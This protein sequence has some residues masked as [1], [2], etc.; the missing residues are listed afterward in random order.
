MNLS[1]KQILETGKTEAV[2]WRCSV[3]RCARVS[4]SDLRP[5]TLSK[6]RLW[7]RYRPV[8]FAKLLWNTFFHRTPQVAASGKNER[9]KNTL[10]FYLHM[11]LFQIPIDSSLIFYFHWK[12]TSNVWVDSS[13][14]SWEN[15][16]LI[17]SLSYLS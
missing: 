1:K 16:T 9:K 2:V 11:K 5:A 8:T 4:F 17:S 10:K 3:N 15:V 13:I 6:K 7:H 14:T 12:Y